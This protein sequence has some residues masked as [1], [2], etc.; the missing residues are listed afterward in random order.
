MTGSNGRAPRSPLGG[1]DRIVIGG[2]TR[3][4]DGSAAGLVLQVPDEKQRSA[5]TVSVV[6]TPSPSY[7]VAHPTRPWLFT[8][9]EGSPATVASYRIEESDALT[10]LTS[11]ATGGD[12][13]CHLTLSSNNQLLLVSNYGSGSVSSFGIADDGALTG[14]LDVL[15]FTGSGADPERQ[16][17]PHAHQTIV[18]GDEIL[19]CDLGTDRIHRL[20]VDGAGRFSRAAEPIHLPAGAGPRH[21]VVVDDR[22]VVACELNAELWVGR[23]EGDGWVQTQRVSTTRAVKSPRQPSGIV[24]D[25]RTVAVATRG[26]DTVATYAIEDGALRPLAEVACGGAWPRA[27]TLRGRWLWV[28]NQNDGTLTVL[29]LD[30]PAAPTPVL[31]LSAPSATCVVL[32]P[33]VDQPPGST[34]R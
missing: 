5:T 14:P 13:A 24:T 27:L 18:V 34:A 33:D 12:S 6:E 20:R 3:E 30:D 16:D 2:Y 29:D 4:M 8:A 21:A 7:V 11:L 15:S 10:E 17:G 1:V 31:E 32:L 28:A 19:A 22:L 23:R 9:G 25:G 26:P